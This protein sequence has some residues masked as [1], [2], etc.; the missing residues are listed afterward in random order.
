MNTQALRPKNGF[1]LYCFQFSLLIFRD[2]HGSHINLLGE[3]L[4][5]RDSC[6]LRLQKM[7]H[8]HHIVYF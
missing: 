8:K 4:I 3:V 5:F 6:G 2:S 7:V 1:L